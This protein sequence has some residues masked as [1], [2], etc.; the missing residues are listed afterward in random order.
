MAVK[1]KPEETAQLRPE[2]AIAGVLALLVAEREERVSDRKDLQRTELL[3]A[4]VGPSNVEIAAVTGKNKDAV[5][6][7]IAR[8]RKAAP[9]G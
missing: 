1:A 4:N 3:L 5:R 6:M 7:A 9:D 8:G 2:V